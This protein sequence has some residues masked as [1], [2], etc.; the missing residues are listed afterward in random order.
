MQECSA[1]MHIRLDFLVGLWYN[2]HINDKGATAA[3]DPK[4]SL[5]LRGLA[6]FGIV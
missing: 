2:M 4:T 1:Y 6:C 5:S 3:K